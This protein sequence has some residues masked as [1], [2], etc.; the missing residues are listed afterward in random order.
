M[1]RERLCRRCASQT[2]SLLFR[3]LADNIPGS[4]LDLHI[5]LPYVFSHNTKANQL[6]TT[7]HTYN[8]NHAGPSGNRSAC[9]ICQKRPDNANQAENGCD[10]AQQGNQFQRSYG[11]ACDPLKCQRQ[12]FSKGVRVQLISCT[13][14][15]ES[16]CLSARVPRGSP[17]F[18]QQTV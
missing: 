17:L 5:Y 3:P 12:H 18:V 11:K 7:E 13:K 9:H 4:M 10:D 16:H 14:Q 15:A 1:C 6:D 2:L 8:T